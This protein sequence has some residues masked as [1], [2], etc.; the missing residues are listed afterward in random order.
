MNSTATATSPRSVRD[1]EADLATA[2]RDLQTAIELEEAASR[3]VD[4]ART[5]NSIGRLLK[6]SLLAH[7]RALSTA[8]GHRADCEWKVKGASRLLQEARE[9]EDQR[10]ARAASERGAALRA[11]GA[12]YTA[13][14]HTMLARFLDDLAEFEDEFRRFNAQAN[15]PSFY[16]LRPPGDFPLIR[17]RLVGSVNQLLG[18]YRPAKKPATTIATNLKED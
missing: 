7:Q 6:G 14:L 2:E 1:F 8:Q 13:Q 18:V 16:R 17:D 4:D 11:A 5:E 3:R 10:K 9:A 12:G 15:M